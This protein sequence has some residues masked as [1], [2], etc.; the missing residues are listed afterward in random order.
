MTPFEHW[1]LLWSAITAVA[2]AATCLVV[3]LAAVFTYRQVSEAGRARK[4]EGALAVLTHIS[5]PELR[6][7]RRLIA[8]HHAEING[9]VTSNPTWAQLESFF[10]NISQGEVDFS[11]FHS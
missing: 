10:K 3:V 5:S 1:Y 9:S 2:T 8:T 6:R 4:L 7:A 11:A